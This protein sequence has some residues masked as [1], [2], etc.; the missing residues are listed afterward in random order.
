MSD[1]LP[2]GHACSAYC[3][4]GEH[5]ELL[6]ANFDHDRSRADQNPPYES[7][8]RHYD[9]AY[10]RRYGARVTRCEPAREAMPIDTRDP[11]ELTTLVG[12]GLG[13]Y[14]WLIWFTPNGGPR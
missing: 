14:P 8:R 1:H 10:R 11:R 2:P 4:D 13:Q 5:C 6:Y 7:V 9:D 12:P 3:R